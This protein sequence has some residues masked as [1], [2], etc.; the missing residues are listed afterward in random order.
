MARICYDDEFKPELEKFIQ[1]I[2]FDK[3][4]D[5]L[6]RNKN[7]RFSAVMRWLIEKYNTQR[8]PKVIEESKKSETLT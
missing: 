6:A 8:G 2:Y 7:Q 3:E 4:L 1:L 5:K